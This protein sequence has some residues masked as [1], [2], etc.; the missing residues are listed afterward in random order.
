MMLR[1]RSVRIRGKEVQLREVTDLSA[2]RVADL[3]ANEAAGS[4]SPNDPSLSLL[5]KDLTAEIPPP[6]IQTFENSGWAF[7][8]KDQAKDLSG[9]VPQAK[10]FIKANGQLALST[11]RL[12]VKLHGDPE[13]SEANS[14]LESFGCRVVKKL[15]FA[16]GLFQIEIFDQAAGDAVDVANQLTASGTCEFAEP[17]L[18]EALGAR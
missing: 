13:P 16:R 11:N 12:V 17:E 8:T 15:T 9:R 5:L 18:I 14:I 4:L 1:E 10:V 3:P 7:V 2:F 6:Q